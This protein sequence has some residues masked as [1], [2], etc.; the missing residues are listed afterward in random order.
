MIPS[1]LYLAAAVKAIDAHYSK[2]S[3]LDSYALMKLAARS[4]L[5]E[6]STR[7]D[8]YSKALIVCGTG[9]NAGDG[10]LVATML[11]DRGWSVNVVLVGGSE[12]FSPASHRA[13]TACKASQA[14]FI[15]P[16]DQIDAETLV[17]DALL[18]VGFRFPLRAEYRSLIRLINCS[19]GPVVALDLP[20]GLHP[21]SGL[22]DGVCIQ[23]TLTITFLVPKLG[24]YHGVGQANAGE[25]VLADLG[26]PDALIDQYS[27]ESVQVLTSKPLPKR[28]ASAHKGQF[29][30]VLIIGG[31]NGFGG[32]CLLATEA[33][34]RSGAGLVSVISQAVHRSS[35]LARCPEAMF[36]AADFNT[37]I[38]AL[39]EKCHAVVIGPG[40]GQDEWAR[41][42][43]NQVLRSSKPTVLDADALNLQAGTALPR[44]NVVLTPHPKEAARL[45]GQQDVSVDRLAVLSALQAV[46]P[47]V[48]VLKGAET[49]VGSESKVGI[50]IYP[51]PGLATGG[52]GDV[53][54]G[55]IGALVAQGH[56]LFDAASL[57]VA[58]H[59]QAGL[60]AN[61]KFGEVGLLAR[62]VIDE[63]PHSLA[64]N[65]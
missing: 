29:G 48:V 58:H 2:D 15:S 37:N 64:G 30:H 63:I 54:A 8:G 14:S 4:V 9:N 34:L 62:D 53:L 6:I 61:Q 18:G 22:S 33:A 10:L 16:P 1:K 25:I 43:L 23:A 50:N 46:H 51:N 40:L 57:G 21:D 59:S 42:L 35:M 7:L 44:S 52:T 20:S 41:N 12:K 32:A 49:L 3:G 19:D 38:E 31:N 5:A 47:S 45:L 11:A 65:L 17:V 26:V 60:M 39:L 13:L 56:S 27:A 55:M 36:S 28:P 24:L